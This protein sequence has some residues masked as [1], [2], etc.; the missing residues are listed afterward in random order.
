MKYLYLVLFFVL[1]YNS[2]TEAQVPR[3]IFVEHFTNTLCSFCAS[4]NPGFYSNL[5]NQNEVVHI[6][7]H[8][9]VPYTQ[10]LLYQQNSA[11]SDARRFYYG[12][13]GTPALVLNG[14]TIPSSSNYSQASIFTPFEAQTSPISIRM[15]QQKYGNDSVKV[16]VI[17]KAEASHNLGTQQLWVGLAEDTVFYA[18]PNGEVE[19]YD[20]YR[21]SLGFLP[22]SIPSV[23]GD[24]LVYNY[25]AFANINWDFNRIF[26]FAMVQNT[27]NKSVTQSE[28]TSPSTNNLTTGIFT[29]KNQLEGIALYPN[30]TKNH[31]NIVLENDLETRVVLYSAI[32]QVVKEEKF[33]GATELFL[34]KLSK[35]IYVIHIS[36]KEGMASQ[37]VILE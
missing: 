31:L 25:T 17:V 24:S 9:G 30:P 3:K 6:S 18:G 29:I 13:S 15:E 32:G 22:I 10:C 2:K 5:A 16:R 36:N 23:L 14:F 37:K 35:G 8:S 34:G 20:V 28:S 7:I 21:A 33:K 1:C 12:I 26:A 4:R 27:S 19:H 11:P